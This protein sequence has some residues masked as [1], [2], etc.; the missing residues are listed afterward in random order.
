MSHV[1]RRSSIASRSPFTHAHSS[2]G[3][4]SGSW[5]TTAF[6]RSSHG[7][8]TPGGS[9]PSSPR[10]PDHAAATRSERSGAG[11]SSVTMQ[12]NKRLSLMLHGAG[13][14]V[15]YS[16]YGVLQEKIMRSSTYGK[17]QHCIIVSCTSRRILTDPIGPNNEH[18]TS[19]SLLIVVNRIFSITTGCVILWYK[20]SRMPEHGSFAARLRPA[21]PY[22]AYASVAL[23]NFLSTTCQYEALKYVSYTTQSLAKTSKMI[24]VLVVG[25]LVWKKQHRPKEWIAGGVIL[26]GCA[27]YLFSAPPAGHKA[28]SGEAAS[29]FMNGLLGTLFLVGYL[30][31][32]GLVSTTQEKVFGKNPSSSDPFGPESPVL[33]QMIWTNSFACAI[34]VAAAMASNATG[35]LLPNTRLLMTSPALLW[36][37]VVFSGASTLGLIVLLNTIAS[38][39][40]LTSSLIMTIRQFLSILINAGIFG[41]FASVSVEGWCG[42]GWVASGI[43]IKINKK[44][45]PPKMSQS[46]ANGDG[47]RQEELEVLVEKDAGPT[48]VL[49]IDS[50]KTKQYIRQ[51]VVPVL[52]P[53]VLA[54]V[55]AAF[56]VPSGALSS[57]KVV[58]AAAQQLEHLAVFGGIR[59]SEQDA[60]DVTALADADAA[61]VAGLYG[62]K[63]DADLHSA[64]DPDCKREFITRPYNGTIKTG[65]VSFPRSGNSY[66]RSLVERATSYQT[67]SVYCDLGLAKTFLGECDHDATFFIKTHFP[68]LPRVYTSA[69]A[70]Y[71]KQY[72]QVVHLIRNPLDSIASW[73]HLSH[74]PK[75]AEGHFDHEAKVSLPGGKF[76]N[77]QRDSLIDMAERWGR[78]AL[79]WSQAPVLTHTLRYEDLKATPMPKMISLLAFLLPEED[80]PPLGDLACIVEPQGAHQPYRS[81]RRSDFASWDSWEPDIRAEVLKIVRRPFCAA[82]YLAVLRNARGEL[83]VE[84]ID[85]C[86]SVDFSSMVDIPDVTSKPNGDMWS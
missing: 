60:Q 73:Y 77:L 63:W 7:Y 70:D 39:G 10:A 57:S 69:R 59:G 27:T 82:G 17:L 32:D 28:H 58:G 75:S 79:Y 80:L 36:D 13:L 1:R 42:V 52:V 65:F 15:I 8:A 5:T 62:G 86:D 41:N 19:S 46:A 35:S 43:W 56:A 84:M 40:A 67:S 83:P 71:Y 44:Y 54:I 24:P 23:F 25:A 81:R 48:R 11:A 45:D 34:A 72:D 9:T 51:Y 55:V 33:D 66:M 22:V 30:F 14:I 31:F 49:Q 16:L 61:D 29:G 78:H 64:L 53:V 3:S 68:A 38:F 50:N 26:L 2:A 21:S 12:A 4:G 85:F 47:Q 20:T 37:V 76:S 18:F 6:D 74:A